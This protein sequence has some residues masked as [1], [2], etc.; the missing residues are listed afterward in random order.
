[1]PL[2]GAHCR[3]LKTCPLSPKSL[4][5]FGTVSTLTKEF[6]IERRAGDEI[7][8][9]LSGSWRQ[10]ILPA[11]CCKGDFFFKKPNGQSGKIWLL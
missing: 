9:D 2:K 1:M 10:N 11:G 3:F 5:R 8:A 4:T 6:N 7:D